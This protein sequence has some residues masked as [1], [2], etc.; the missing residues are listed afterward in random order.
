M[1]LVS[2]ENQAPKFMEGTRTFRVVMED[3]EA[4]DPNDDALANN[5]ENIADN[6]GSRIVA[7]DANGDMPTYT[8]GGTDAS[9]FRIRSN[10]QIEVK[11]E[12][13]HE[14][15]SNHTVTLT[16]ND[17]T[18][19]SND[20]A[21]ITVTIY[22]TDVDE[23][24]K[25]KDRAD[26]T[27]DGMREVPYPENGDGPVAR[28]TASD[29]E[30]ATP[31]FWSLVQSED[32]SA[33][34]SDG[35]GT[36][37]IVG[38]DVADENLF[39]ID[40]DGVLSF[41]TSPSYED[42]SASGAGN[43]EAKNYQVVVQVSD[44]NNN[45]YFELTV[46]VTDVEET[47]KVTWNV[48]PTTGG[49][50]IPGLQQFQ[51]GAMLTPSVTDPDGATTVTARKWY[52]GS[53]EITGET[54]TG[55]TYIV[56][57]DDV[58]NRI[59][60]DATYTDANGGPAETVS[61]TSPHPVQAARL[62]GDNMVPVFSSTIVTRRV[63]EN[64]KGNV[65]GPVTATDGNGDK[66]TYTLGG[67]DVEFFEIDMATGQLMVGDDTKINYETKNQYVVTVTATD[68]SGIP[69][70]DAAMVTI[71]VINVD[72]KPTFDTDSPAG[73]VADPD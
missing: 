35:D 61:F 31:G 49:T 68:S 16:A 67:T 39:E 8:L 38:D 64:S 29:P 1:V 21:T 32:F 71:N 27:A 42:D 30:G 66:L 56:V 63:E 5:A 9:L 6:V 43:A 69:T 12:L 19:T 54:G 44:G 3:V 26:S 11:G 55:A 10:G 57:A 73:V 37:D 60:V 14:M 70:A 20:R 13:D 40:Q 53:S 23:A 59:R 22:V 28:F 24:P 36:E 41:E 65:G 45:G 2:Q 51:P 7:T 46:K 4:A 52:R 50:S 33:I 47:G 62:S 15:D 17:G 34:D 58:G 72:E 48:V 25:I 18:G